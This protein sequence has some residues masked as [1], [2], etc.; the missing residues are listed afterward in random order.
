MRTEQVIRKRLDL[1]E[2]CISLGYIIRLR[3]T[4]PI[5][6]LEAFCELLRWVLG[7]EKANV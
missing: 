6:N 2:E 1:I 5:E 7:E 3:A 4:T